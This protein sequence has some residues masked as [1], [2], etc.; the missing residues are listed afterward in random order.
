MNTGNCV[1]ISAP[2]TFYGR[3]CPEKLIALF[4]GNIALVKFLSRSQS[5][6]EVHDWDAI[7]LRN[8]GM[9]PHGNLGTLQVIN[10][11][12]RHHS[13][14]SWRQWNGVSRTESE[15]TGSMSFPFRTGVNAALG[16]C[17][18]T[19]ESVSF[20]SHPCTCIVILKGVTWHP[21]SRTEVHFKQIWSVKC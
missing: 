11:H 3:V 19:G 17:R 2:S 14:W 7:H 6:E 9:T 16:Q 4:W 20:H 12:S 5:L 15:D 1:Q 18:H 13:R 21:F 10:H 8:I